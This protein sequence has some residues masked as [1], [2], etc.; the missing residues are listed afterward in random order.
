MNRLK[1]RK[2]FR[3]LLTAVLCAAVSVFCVACMSR[4]SEA[5]DMDTQAES[6]SD[7]D[8]AAKIQAQEAGKSALY[9]VLT[10]E[11]LVAGYEYVLDGISQGSYYLYDLTDDGI[12]E[13]IAGDA[14]K[15]IYTSRDGSISAIG[16]VDADSLYSS[17]EYGLLAVAKTAAGW[18]LDSYSYSSG[19]M[20]KKSLAA[21][22]NRQDFNGKTEDVLSRSKELTR[23]DVS[24][25]SVFRN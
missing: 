25:R 4:D 18:E 14:Q 16:T 2:V 22:S 21:E 15:T 5:D 10:D 6:A 13:L 12:P 7:L 20:N 17:E 9:G 8:I 23:F 24:D 3:A 19:L 11:T 1:N